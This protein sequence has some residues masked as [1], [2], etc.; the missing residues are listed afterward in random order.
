MAK[1]ATAHPAPK[2]AGALVNPANA[3]T[4]KSILP[5]V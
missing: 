4:I 3:G 5:Y 1:T 2:A